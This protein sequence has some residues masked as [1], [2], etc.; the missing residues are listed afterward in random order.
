MSFNLLSKPIKIVNII[1]IA[2]AIINFILLLSNGEG[3]YKIY[4]ITI[5]WIVAVVFMINGI[6]IHYK[7]R[8]WSIYAMLGSVI[9]AALTVW[10]MMLFY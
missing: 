8:S 3:S 10:Q 1:L 7:K 6:D 2:V 4:G 5:N 9:V